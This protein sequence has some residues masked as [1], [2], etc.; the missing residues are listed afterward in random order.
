MANS[1]IT[2]SKLALSLASDYDSVFVINPT[3][4]SYNEYTAMTDDKE[5]KLRWSGDNF[6]ADIESECKKQVYPEDQEYFLNMLKKETIQETLRNSKSFAVK[7]R[8]YKD[9]EPIYYHLKI[10]RGYDDNIIIGVKNV[11]EQV[12]REMQVLAN[13]KTYSEIADA[14]ASRYEFIYYIDASNDSYKL[15]SY[16]ENYAKFS[17]IWEGDDFYRDT[18]NDIKQIIHEDDRERVLYE[19]EKEHLMENLLK[20]GSLTITYRQIINNDIQYINI[21]IVLPKEDHSHFIVAVA[22]VTASNTMELSVKEALGSAMEMAGK[23]S[24]TGA[25]NKTAYVLKEMSLDKKID[26]KTIDKFAIIVCDINGLK[27]VNDIQGHAA[28]DQYIKDAYEILDDIFKK[29]HVYRY[30]GDEFAIIL[31]KENFDNHLRLISEFELKMQEQYENNKVTMAYGISLYNPETD[32]RVQDVFER[33]DQSMYRNKKLLK[34]EKGIKPVV[35]DVTTA[36]YKDIEFYKLF[37]EL[38]QTMTNVGGIDKPKIESLLIEIS[39]LLRLAKGIT[40]VF[41]NPIEEK[42]NSGEILCCYDTK[43]ECVPIITHRVVSNVMSGATMTVFM[44]PDEP[45]LTDT[46]RKRAELV[47]RTTL[48]YITRNRL[49]DKVEEL[50]FYD[51]NGYKNLRNFYLYISKISAENDYANKSIV[52][53]NLRHFSL[54][55]RELGRKTGDIIMRRHYDTLAE[56]VD[57][58][59]TVA[60][61]GGDNFI[62]FCGNEKLGNVLSY[63][64]EASV[65]YDNSDGKCVNISTSAGVFRLPDGYVVNSPKDV[66]EYV[67]SAFNI[68][69]NGGNEHIIFYNDEIINSREKSM[70]VQQLFPQAL[71]NE[72]FHVFY[73]P[74]VNIETGELVGA[75]ALCR[76]FHD[77][78]I[79]PPMNFI[80]MLEETNEICKLDFY[81][82]DHVC[83]DISRWLNEGKKVI[84]VSV[85]LSRKHMV[86]ANILESILKIVDRHNV[87]HSCIEIELT[88]TTTDVEFNDLKRVVNGLQRVGIYT[89]VDDF[90]IGYSSLN[91]IRE[92]PWNVIKVDKSF[93]PVE[94]DN[95]DKTRTIMFKY[96][97]AMARELG[98]EC[99][100]EGVETEKQ[101]EILRENNCEFAQGFY[102]DKPLPVREFETR[103]S[104]NYYN[105]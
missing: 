73:Q 60:R 47:M 19:L 34:S 58:N 86:N 29:S 61:L 11:D 6:Y 12:K 30:G 16:S 26:Q 104:Q 78:N 90:G 22:N 23:D 49:G 44:S 1:L 67:I 98:I 88:E 96:I 54:I 38:I 99:I 56:M 74:K 93:L 72:E 42:N 103:M 81:M 91:L 63:L 87:P 50:T 9:N 7:Y 45:P 41:K 36:D 100:V 53:Y 59:G 76:W 92:V 43:Q 28:G 17:N 71:R 48:S 89:S 95:D 2:Y 94:K 85:N 10:I 51:E 21:L 35:E 68:A 40:H 24:L 105:K 37:E 77:G 46:E 79:V 5:L 62:L 57:S 13:S 64:S 39:K 83:A 65:M 75:E 70:H 82:L 69:Q 31:E 8:L 3:D 32:I 52:R 20:S 33:A 15:Y 18:I 27:T 102:F 84:R 14:L 97:V 4:D 101:L 25:E 66:M 80:P 55:N